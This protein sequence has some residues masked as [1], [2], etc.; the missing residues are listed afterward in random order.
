MRR[1]GHK[2]RVIGGSIFVT[3]EWPSRV[4]RAGDGTLATVTF[5]S[6]R[7]DARTQKF[8]KD[9]VALARERKLPEALP[10]SQF[11]S[12]SYDVVYIY[13]E[14]M[15]RAKVSGDAAKLAEERKAIRDEITKL[16]D[17]P[18]I[19]GALTMGPDRDMLKSV[20]IIEARDDTWKLIDVAN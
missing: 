20:Y 7:D 5:F 15:R 14:A 18:G 10:P 11:D 17:F 6:G 9:F 4:G 2:G 13:A 8:V 1:Q 12:A 16:K 19:E 3:P